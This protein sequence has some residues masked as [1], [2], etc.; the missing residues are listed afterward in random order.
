M[1]LPSSFFPLLITLNSGNRN[2]IFIGQ[3]IISHDDSN[4][5]ER[6]FDRN[7]WEYEEEYKWVKLEDKQWLELNMCVIMC[8]G[9]R[10]WHRSKGTHCPKLPL[11][12]NN[13][14]AHMRL[15][16]LSPLRRISCSWKR[17]NSI[18]VYTCMIL[19]FCTTTSYLGLSA[20]CPLHRSLQPPGATGLLLWYTPFFVELNAVSKAAKGQ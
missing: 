10:H 8:N 15:L 4:N 12:V 2:C 1:P 18:L 6:L 13:S 16:T 5:C 20:L 3:Q 7:D 14:A 17:F 9:Q 11:I 19:F